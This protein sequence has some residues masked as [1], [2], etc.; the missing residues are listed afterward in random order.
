MTF[1]GGSGSCQK[2]QCAGNVAD[3]LQSVSGTIRMSY[4]DK[5]R[6]IFPNAYPG[7]DG[8]SSRT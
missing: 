2:C 4:M 3:S 7:K 8:K 1:T 5:V 6:E